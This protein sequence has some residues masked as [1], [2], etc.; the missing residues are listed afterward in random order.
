MK[1]VDQRKDLFRRRL[2][3]GGALEA[4]PIRLGRGEDEDD[5]DG[6]DKHN[7]DDDNGFEH[8]K[9]QIR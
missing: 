6:D 3:R 8:E 1:V 4:E 5:C 7:G 9:L 2:D